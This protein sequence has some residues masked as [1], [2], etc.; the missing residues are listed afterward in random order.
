MS[1]ASAPVYK[2]I[3]FRKHPE[4]YR[5]GRGEQG[6]LTAEPYK[7]ELLGLWRFRTPDVAEQS[8]RAL[9]KC[10]TAYRQA[11]DFVGMDMA[12][13][14]IQ[15]GVTRARRYANHAAGRK[16]NEDKSV[17]PGHSDALKAQCAGIFHHYLLM[18]REDPVYQNQKTEHRK[19][20]S[21]G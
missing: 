18:I 1:P 11:N 8:A 14:F 20:Q 5:I 9:Y 10:Y 19:R 6:V 3:D 7:S 12:R 2:D 21:R 4:A 15:M 13:K 16:Y 17:R